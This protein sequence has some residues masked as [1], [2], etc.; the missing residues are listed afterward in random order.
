MLLLSNLCM[1]GRV[2]KK[3]VVSL[4][5]LLVGVV[6]LCW[7]VLWCSFSVVCWCKVVMVVFSV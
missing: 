1:V 4:V 7:W 2:C 3:C 6:L 5:V